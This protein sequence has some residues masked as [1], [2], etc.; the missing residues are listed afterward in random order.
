[1]CSQVVVGKVPITSNMAATG[2]RVSCVLNIALLHCLLQLC[3]VHLPNLSDAPSHY[4]AVCRALYTET[5]ELRTFLEKI[6][7]AKEVGPCHRHRGC[8]LV[9]LFVLDTLIAVLAAG[10]CVLVTQYTENI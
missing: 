5:R 8:G 9:L 6:K 1:M 7:S 10:V 2:R 4:Q 3:M